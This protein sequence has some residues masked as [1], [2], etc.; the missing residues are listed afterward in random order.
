[1]Q[2]SLG[3]LLTDATFSS[4][5][6]TSPQGDLAQADFWNAAVAGWWS[7]SSSGLLERLL[8]LEAALGRRRD[9]SRPKGPR[10]VDLDLLLFGDEVVATP[11]LSVPHPELVN[12]R[13]ALEPLVELCPEAVDSR[14]GTPWSRRL[15]SLP[16][17]GVDRT[18]LPW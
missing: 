13:F 14:D 16:G 12:R 5:Y 11:R 2:A 9:S 3:R 7:G 4:L 17:Q 6:R 15:A 10:V 18:S 1:M 8:M